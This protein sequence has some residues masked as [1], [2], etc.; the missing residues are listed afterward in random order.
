MVSSSL[1]MASYIF[2]VLLWT[3]LSQN[4]RLFEVDFCVIEVKLEAIT[5]RHD[6]FDSQYIHFLQ[7]ADDIFEFDKIAA[8]IEADLNSSRNNAK[9]MYRSSQIGNMIS[10]KNSKLS[11][12]KELG[13]IAKVISDLEYKKEKDKGHL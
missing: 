2:S 3:Q 5:L 13:S 12:V 4:I 8:D 7:D 11:A 9:T 1:A 6:F 10:A